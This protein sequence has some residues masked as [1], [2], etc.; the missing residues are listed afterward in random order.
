VLSNKAELDDDCA[1]IYR[2]S[3]LYLVSNALEEQPR[4]PG[5]RDGVPLLG[6]EKFINADKEL[7]DLFTRENT[8]L[9]VSPNNEAE[10]LVV[11]AGARRHGD[12]DDDHQ[13]VRGTLA[14]M[15]GGSSNRASAAA[16]AVELDFQRSDS[17]LRS[18]REMI[19]VRSM[20][21]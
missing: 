18:R 4:I 15:L 14:Y 9:V 20:S 17:S 19:D 16:S 5:F 12:F 10:G 2:K 21:R 1:G 6:M 13:T 11:S 3:L 8:R 7:G